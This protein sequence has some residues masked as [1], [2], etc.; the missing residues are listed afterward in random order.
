[1]LTKHFELRYP[2]GMFDNGWLKNVKK[3]KRQGRQLKPKIRLFK[4]T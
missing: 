4:Y 2:L 1:M 3:I